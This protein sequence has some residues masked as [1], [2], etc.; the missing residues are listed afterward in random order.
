MRTQWTTKGYET[1]VLVAHVFEDSTDIFG[2]SGG[3]FEH[4]KPPPFGTPLT[5]E[6][7]TVILIGTLWHAACINCMKLIVWCFFLADFLFLGVV[8]DWDKYIFPWQMYFIWGV[9]LD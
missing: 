9:I 4:P 6:M 8:L 3:E 2:I 5:V 1:P 7:E